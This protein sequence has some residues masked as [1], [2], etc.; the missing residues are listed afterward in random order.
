MSKKKP[1]F[2]NIPFEK[3]EAVR[4]MIGFVPKE[5]EQKRIHDAFINELQKIGKVRTPLDTSMEEVTKARSAPFGILSWRFREIETV[6][7]KEKASYI[8]LV[9]ELLENTLLLNNQEKWMST[10]WEK[11]SYLSA[12]GNPKK[13]TDDAIKQIEKT[14]A[15]FSDRYA[16]ANPEK[17]GVVFYVS[18]TN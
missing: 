8:A 1:A 15:E 18:F 4:V 13:A 11:T 2:E 3:L 10:V 5:L 12:V 9:C 17:K 16:K 7:A 14:I 6:N